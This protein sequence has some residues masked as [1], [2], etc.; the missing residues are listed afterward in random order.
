MDREE[1]YIKRYSYTRDQSAEIGENIVLSC[2]RMLSMGRYRTYADPIGTSSSEVIIFDAAKPRL[3][4][5][6]MSIAFASRRI[7]PPHVQFTFS[8]STLPD[9]LEKLALGAIVDPSDGLFWNAWLVPAEDM[10]IM[11]QV[12]IGQRKWRATV[13]LAT[14]DPFGRWNCRT[15]RELVQRF[16]EV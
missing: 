13:Q 15:A 7:A 6:C 12:G 10:K 1:Y 4:G 3:L 2:L 11:K 16:G 9:S 5:V 8:F 14:K